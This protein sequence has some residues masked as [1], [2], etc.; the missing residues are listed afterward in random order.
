MWIPDESRLTGKFRYVEVAY[1]HPQHGVRREMAG[2]NKPRFY[3]IEDL[4]S[5]IDRHDNTGVYKS[6][7]QYD[8]PS[9]DANKLGP[10]Y[11]DFDHD[12]DPDRSRADAS[13]LVDY[14]V[15]S[16]IP[17]KAINVWFTGKKGF[18]VEVEPIPLN[19]SPKTDLAPI[20]R[21]IASRLGESL[22]L[23]THDLQVYDN[24]RI[25]RIPNSKHQSTGLYKIQLTLE[26]LALPI[27]EISRL[28]SQPRFFGVVPQE[29]SPEAAAWFREWQHDYEF[30]GVSTQDYIE[31]FLRLG[32]G[33]VSQFKD[34][35]E[36]EFDAK[37]LFDSCHALSRLWDKAEKERHLEHEERLFLASI[38]AYTELGRE[39]LHGI[40]ALC[41]D[42]DYNK[43]QEHIDDWLERKRKGI[44][45]H[46]FSC[47]RANEAG[48]GCGD[49][50]LEPKPKYERVG[51]KLVKTG[52]YSEPSPVR[53]AYRRPA[54]G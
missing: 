54:R 35:S 52:E 45:G 4:K 29:F 51:D 2:A 18:H 10:L 38:L 1:A 46:P 3:H 6:V 30:Q 33:S 13:A 24:R 42:Y 47:R 31:R 25:W 28:A 7:W 44:G 9:V 22:G 41:V 23:D 5:F 16:G 34:D 20:Y 48:I 14:F 53:F 11:F 27:D 8:R 17:E 21:F 43:P 39:T 37:S 36:L 50:D 15:R 40:L 12:T 32:S 19:I 26:E 49:C